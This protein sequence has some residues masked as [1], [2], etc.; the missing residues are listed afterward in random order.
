[1][2]SDE[3][4]NRFP[5]NVPTELTEDEWEQLKRILAEGAPEWVLDIRK[6]LGKDG[7]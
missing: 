3:L 6:E 7:D 2:Q 5:Y 1:M 4:P